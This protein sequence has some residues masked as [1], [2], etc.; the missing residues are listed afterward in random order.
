M[1]APDFAWMVKPLVWT[2]F[3]TGCVRAETG[4][5]RYEIMWV[6]RNGLCSLDGPRVTPGFTFHPNLEA[7]QAAA[8]ADC[9][10]RMLSDLDLHAL[11]ARLAEAVRLRDAIER[12]ADQALSNEIPKRNAIAFP[13]AD[14]HAGYDAAIR[15]ARKTL[16]TP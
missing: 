1:S 15:I 4:L 10:A 5:G 9:T 8:Q 16:A 14:W 12:T 11:E 13:S 3:G 2:P 6:R 7:A